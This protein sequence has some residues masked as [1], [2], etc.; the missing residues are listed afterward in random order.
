MGN[1]PP[2]LKFDSRLARPSPGPPIGIVLEK[3]ATVDTPLELTI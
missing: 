2:I 3:T 1:T